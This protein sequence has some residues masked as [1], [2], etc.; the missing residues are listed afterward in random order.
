MNRSMMIGTV[1]GATVATAAGGF[2]GYRMLSEPKYAEV[3]EVTPVTE[4]VETPREECHDKQVTRQK[5]VK[6]K[7]QVTGTVIGA[8]AG[9]L[10]GNALGGGGGNTG[11]K[12]AG[13]AVGGY[14]GNK[15]HE[16]VQEG[17][18]ETV[19]E[20]VCNTVTDVT[21][22]TIGYDVTYRIGDE[23]GQ[24]R[25]DHDPGEAIPLRDG[26]LV[27]TQRSDD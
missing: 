23:A 2:A 10:L 9:G 5:A 16:K 17:N 1:F 13:A 14:A 22:R 26:Q 3:V 24:V 7:H 12:L 20:T 8:V 18:T 19:T 4:R 6:D 27:L 25:M 11:A 21:Q 15:A